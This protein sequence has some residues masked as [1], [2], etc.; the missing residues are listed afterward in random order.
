MLHPINPDMLARLDKD[1]GLDT[2][3]TMLNLLRFEP[4]G[5][6][7]RYFNHYVLAFRQI[8]ADFAIDATEAVWIGEVRGML[9]GPAEEEWDAVLLVRYPSVAAFRAIAES[10]AYRLTAAPL[11]KASV[12]EWRL[13]CQTV[14]AAAR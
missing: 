3:V 10:E 8:A 11:H 6:R 7:E 12:R 1:L 9:A 13:V 14:M 2:P 4:D 5:G